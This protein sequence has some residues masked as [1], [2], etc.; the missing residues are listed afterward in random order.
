MLI[1]KKHHLDLINKGKR[2]RK[3]MRKEGERGGDGKEKRIGGDGERK[4]PLDFH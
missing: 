4:D 2:K 3:V 1:E